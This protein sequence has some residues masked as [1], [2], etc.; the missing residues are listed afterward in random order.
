[1][2]RK[3]REIT[4][5][6]EINSIIKNCKTC[7]VAMVDDGMP[8][9]VPLS[10]GY[11]ISEKELSLYFHSAKEGRKIDIL[12][13]NNTVCF[14]MCCEGEPVNAKKTPCNSGYYYSS[15]IG[16]G[17][18]EFVTDIDE[19]IEALTLLLKHQ[20]GID[21]SFT[22]QQANAVCIYKIVTNDFTGKK[23]LRPEE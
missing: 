13:K 4:D 20:A 18:V 5:I 21:V 8:Y 2:Q 7:H 14:D 17:N 10:F 19:K 23:K 12:H 11:E 16:N 22:E 6:E 1:M 15:V 3:D 9:V